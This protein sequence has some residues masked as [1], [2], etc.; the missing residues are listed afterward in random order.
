MQ[1]AYVRTDGGLRGS[2]SVYDL[3]DEMIDVDVVN[4]ADYIQVSTSTKPSITYTHFL[5]IPYLLCSLTAFYP[6]SLLVSLCR[7]TKLPLPLLLIVLLKLLLLLLLHEQNNDI[8]NYHEDNRNQKM[9]MKIK[10]KIKIK[11]KIMIIMMML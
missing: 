10:I 7:L 6:A 4:L 1:R 3:I 8:K 9:K 5:S 11:M 2:I